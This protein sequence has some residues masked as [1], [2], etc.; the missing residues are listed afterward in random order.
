MD[1]KYDVVAKSWLY[2]NTLGMLCTYV[3]HLCTS[4][5]YI[6]EK[7]LI[8]LHCISPPMQQQVYK[9]MYYIPIFHCNLQNYHLGYQIICL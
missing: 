4:Q 7:N 2:I 3:C 1:E 6:V 5:R 8:D 9:L